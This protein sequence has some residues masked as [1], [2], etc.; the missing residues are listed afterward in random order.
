MEDVKAIAEEICH[1]T[2]EEF[3]ELNIRLKEHHHSEITYLQDIYE[4]GMLS[5]SSALWALKN[6]LPICR[7]GWNGKGMFVVRQIPA[8]ITADIIPNMQSLPQSAKDILMSR[9]DPHIDYTCQMLI[10]RQD[11]R[12]DSWVPS[13]AD[14]MADDWMIYK[15]D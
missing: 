3:D 14:V 11:G 8:H 15:E 12:A 4:T 1:L 13:A 7:Q 6:G 10:I 9:K 5:F 2:R